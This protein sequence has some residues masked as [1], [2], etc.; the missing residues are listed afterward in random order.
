MLYKRIVE[1]N[2][3]RARTNSYDYL[4][5]CKHEDCVWFCIWGRKQRESKTSGASSSSSFSSSSST[6]ARRVALVALATTPATLKGWECME[7]WKSV[8]LQ[9]T[10]PFTFWPTSP[11]FRPSTRWVRQGG[12][13]GSR[14]T[15]ILIN[16]K[17]S[18][19][20]QSPKPTAKL[21]NPN[22]CDSMED[23]YQFS[24]CSEQRSTGTLE[25]L[26]RRCLY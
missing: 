14:R 23:R 13:P 2:A 9:L 17:P 4:R 7:A 22:S 5:W 25:K 6:S 3:F 21:H 8:R 12:P 11:N 10:L 18:Q 19:Q 26:C 24:T 20:Q 16:P 15:C 1:L